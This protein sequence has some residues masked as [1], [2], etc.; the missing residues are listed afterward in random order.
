MIATASHQ[1]TPTLTVD[2]DGETFAYRDLGPRNGV[3]V[4][5]LEHLAGS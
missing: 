5:F 3:P 4:I 2:V 1:D